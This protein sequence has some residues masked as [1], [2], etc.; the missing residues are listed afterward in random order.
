MAFT[1]S[2]RLTLPLCNTVSRRNSSS[3]V[4]SYWL[5]TTPVT[6]NVLYVNPAGSP[7]SEDAANP[8]CSF[9]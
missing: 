5:G 6:L 3:M 7:L 9:Q 8:G 2:L 4:G 1:G